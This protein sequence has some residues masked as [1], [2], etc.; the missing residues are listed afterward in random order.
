MRAD[1]AALKGLMI[2][3]VSV[4][5]SSAPMRIEWQVAG[6][7]TVLWIA[8]LGTYGVSYFGLFDDV[9][10]P[11]N[12]IEV[13]VYLA[14]LLVPLMCLWVAAWVVRQTNAV[15]SDT[16]RLAGSVDHLEEAL[17]L[18]TP[19]TADM[20]VS[21]IQ[22]AAHSAVKAEQSRMTTQIRN[23][24]E[25][26]RRVADSVK[27]LL[28]ARDKD[29]ATISEIVETA[30]HVTTKAAQ[31]AGAADAA[32]VSAMKGAVDEDY[33]TEDLLDQDALPLDLGATPDSPTLYWSDINRALNFPADQN[34]QATFEAIDSIIPHR[35]L[36]ALMEKAETILAALAEEG[37]YTDDL[38]IGDVNPQHWHDFANGTRGKDV[39][40]VGA[41]RDA[42]AL[43]LAKGR[44]RN[45]PAFHETTFEFLRMFDR[46]L[47]DFLGSA[48]TEDVLDLAETRTARAFQLL[49][50]ITGAFD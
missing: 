26:Q 12:F 24:S 47:Q 7:L 4:P 33:D 31:R 9:A 43:A 41:I 25:E 20:V 49:A 30:K 8:G 19:A 5:K 48:K 15:R 1:I 28:K 6:F 27:L 11:A 32:R 50:R 34:D 13:I 39:A 35:G 40:G 14:T 37:I 44:L 3:E 38:T 23:L 29:Q 21:A 18:S 42:A 17:R 45:D 2:P 22:E 16:N 46:F 36:A 10:R